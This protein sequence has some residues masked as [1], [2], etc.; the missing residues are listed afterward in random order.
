M[1]NIALNK[2]AYDNGHMEPYGP[3]RAVDGSWAP[4]SRWLRTTTPAWLGVDLGSTYWVNRWIVKMMGFAGWPAPNYNMC[5]FKLQGS[6]DNATW[7]DMD[8]VTDN[9][10]SQVDRTCPAKKAR[11]ARLYVTKGLRINNPYASVMEF[12]LYE[13]ADAPY[14]S[15]LTISSGSLNPAFNSKHFT[16][17][18]SVANTVSSITVTP[19]AAASGATIKVDG[20]PVQSGQPSQSIN[21]AVGTTNV[22]VVVTSADGTMSETY[23]IAVTRAGSAAYLSNLILKMLPMNTP[24]TLTPPFVKTTFDYT[25]SV[26]NGVTGVTVTPTAEDSGAVI[27]VNNVVVPSGSPSGTIS[28]NVGNNTIT[29]LVTFGTAQSTYTII[30]TRASA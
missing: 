21:L 14:L 20:N 28:L 5:D 13:S 24:K 26:A 4:T 15:N 30:V 12:E 22:S 10:A 9:S 3:A 25:A 7:F 6:L 19:T 23:T 16:Y 11:Y 8:T 18:D 1:S 27:K 29:I 2:Y 17:A